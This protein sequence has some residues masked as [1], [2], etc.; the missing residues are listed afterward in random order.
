ME[1]HRAHRSSDG[2]HMSREGEERGSEADMSKCADGQI[3]DTPPPPLITQMEQ[4]ENV[5]Q[6]RIMSRYN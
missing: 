6:H 5:K 2:F 3:L 1:E 4:L